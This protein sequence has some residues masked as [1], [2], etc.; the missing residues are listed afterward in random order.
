MFTPLDI[1]TCILAVVVLY[2][3]YRRG[4]WR[5]LVHLAVLV[6]AAVV[7]NI[8]VLTSITI[9]N[10]TEVKNAVIQLGGYAATLQAVAFGL[11][12]SFEWWLV[13][14]KT[15]IPLRILGALF[16]FIKVFGFFL[17][18]S[19]ALAMQNPY[20]D[21]LK[22]YPETL[23]QSVFIQQLDALTGAIYFKLA[24]HGYVNYHKIQFDKD[25]KKTKTETRLQ[26]LLQ[27]W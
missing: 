2:L 5:E 19:L 25:R 8:F 14:A 12:T 9:D 6:I 1:G 16:S 15:S 4:F 13:P 21:R 18:L 11:S 24:E 22:Y 27:S 23:K 3:G 20:V 7:T 10:A 17:A 26:R